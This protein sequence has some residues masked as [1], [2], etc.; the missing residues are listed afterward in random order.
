VEADRASLAHERARKFKIEARWQIEDILERAALLDSR[1]SAILRLHLEKGT[2]FRDIACL[3]GLNER[4]VS[5]RIRRLMWRLR[6]WR[7]IR[8]TAGGLNATEMAMARSYVIR[9][10][11]IRSVAQAHGAD[12][13]TVARSLAK[14]EAVTGCRFVFRR[15]K[16]ARKGETNERLCKC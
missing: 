13:L 6:T 5:R 2:T 15:K 10:L 16:P 9:G 7:C 3:T 4:A 11:S 14:V 1:D 12:W 8:L